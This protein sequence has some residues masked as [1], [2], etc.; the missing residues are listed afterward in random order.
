MAHQHDKN[1]SQYDPKKPTIVWL[2]RRIFGRYSLSGPFHLW[3]VEIVLVDVRLRHIYINFVI[4]I[5][6]VPLQ[7]GYPLYTNFRFIQ[8][9]VKGSW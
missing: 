7:Y 8:A 2:L 9:L 6:R 1:K 3:F 5:N 4:M